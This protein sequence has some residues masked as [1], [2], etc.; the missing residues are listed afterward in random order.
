M[1]RLVWLVEKNLQGLCGKRFH[2]FTLLTQT[3]NSSLEAASSCFDAYSS[4][5]GRKFKVLL[6]I[7]KINVQERRKYLQRY[8]ML[9][10]TVVVIL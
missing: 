3:K 9:S 10:C 8:R 1:F 6:K 5:P 4:F 2:S 7:C